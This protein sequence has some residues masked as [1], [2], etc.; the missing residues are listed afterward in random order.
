MSRMLASGPNGYTDTDSLV[1]CCEE[2]LIYVNN[3]R[4]DLQDSRRLQRRQGVGHLRPIDQLPENLVPISLPS[5]G[6]DRTSL[7]FASTARYQ[8]NLHSFCLL[9]QDLS[10]KNCHRSP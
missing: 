9:C 10:G 8:D 6:R 3:C 5:R 4:S 1:Y 2:V 7:D